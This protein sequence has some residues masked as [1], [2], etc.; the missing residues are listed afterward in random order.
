MQSL[1][2]TSL[3]RTV[4]RFQPTMLFPHYYVMLHC[5]KID[6]LCSR[7]IILI[8]YKNYLDVYLDK[9]LPED[10]FIRMYLCVVLKYIICSIRVY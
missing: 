10:C 7:T 5:L 9:F 2:I 3:S 4:A 1:V 8:Q 6:L